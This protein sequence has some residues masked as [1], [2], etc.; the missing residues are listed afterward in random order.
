MHH[1]ALS[2]ENDY[3][4]Q[5]KVN[6]PIRT[7]K[8][9]EYLWDAVLAGDIDTV[10]SDHACLPMNLKKGDIWKALP[11]FGGTSLIFPVV[12][13]NGYYQR[14]LPL[15][16]IAELTSFN[17]DIKHNLYP[18]KGTIMV[19]SDADLAIVDIET[20]KSVRN[21]IL[22]SAQDY[23]PFEGIPLKG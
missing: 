17:S 13:T 15:E 21:D 23:T 10:V 18:K 4:I 22:F 3:G 1:L 19:G 14:S 16:R 2:Y 12:I 20:E 7:D 8:D 11:G 9:V 6:P 5:G